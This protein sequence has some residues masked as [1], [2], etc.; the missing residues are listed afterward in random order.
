MMFGDDDFTLRLG[1]MRGR[2][3]ARRARTYLSRIVQAANLARGGGSLAGG[4]RSGF[5]G[6]RIGR[7]S[8]PARMLA[9]RDRFAHF[10]ARRVLV[11]SHIV[12]LTGKGVP[13]ARAHLRYLQRDGTTREGAPGQL[14]DAGRDDAD[15]RGFLERG[16]GDRHQFRFIVSAEDGADY[17]DLKPLTRQLMTRMA[18]DLDT[19]LD[20]VA[21]DHFNTGHPHT[22][23]LLRGIDET[24]KDLVI[25]RE[26]L[27][28]GMRERAAEIISL[29]LGPRTDRDIADRLRAEVTQ[30]RLTSIDRALL[31]E[32]DADRLLLP[33]GRDGFEQALR[34]GRLQTLYRMG[35]AAPVGAGRWQLAED[36]D[37][38]LTKIG[39]RGDIIRTMQRAIGAQGLERADAD[40]VIYEP[41]AIDARPLTGRV[42]H[43][44]LSDELRDRHYLV[45]DATDG[46]THYVDIGGGES[47]GA[48]PENAIVRID[49][50]H[51]TV[52][53]VDRTVAAVAAGNGGLYDIDAHLR[54]DATATE[55]FAETHVRRLEAIRRATGGAA[56]NADGSW[57]IAQDHLDRV[58][59]YEAVRLR[60]QPVRLTLL[61]TQPLDRLVDADAATLLDRNL[62]DGV[63]RDHRDQG[64]GRELR[65]AEA[66]RRLWLVEQGLAEDRDGTT[67]YR[68]TL[69]ADLQRRDVLRV[70][71]QMARELGL[72][73][74]EA[75][76]GE[77]IAGTLRRS[78]DLTSGKF[79]VIERSRDF[80]LVPWRAVLERQLGKPISGILRDDG[81]TWTMGRARGGPAI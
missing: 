29:D 37:E 7:G 72:D 13:G 28:R 63:H 74:T 55:A 39:E 43:R 19:D 15:G 16:S 52:R 1:R 58:A 27:T 4:R 40:H 35:L 8:G 34:A 23:I 76:V 26:Y 46:R 17:Q 9:S 64:F 6:A 49:P 68:P 3:G 33:G 21:V 71:G 57:T 73:F 48:A 77:T 5:T 31:R 45:V 66:R 70:A 11:K 25:A 2:G 22:H 69:L 44:G 80:T 18:E 60:D 38:T 56:R 65:E 54:H 42:L 53:E 14:Y 79:A 36:L 41:Q 75:K 10:R 62:I 12:R 61:A 78:A 67:R 24:G 47:V 50:P 20:W 32:A 51:G 81:V 59:A 30:E